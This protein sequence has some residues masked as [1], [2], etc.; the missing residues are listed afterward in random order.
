MNTG[1]HLQSLVDQ[2]S[3]QFN[4]MVVFAHEMAAEW[5][6]L[7][8]KDRGISPGEPKQEMAAE[9]IDLYCIELSH[10][11]T[12]CLVKE[13]VAMESEKSE[14]KRWIENLNSVK[15]SMWISKFIC[16]RCLKQSV[17]GQNRTRNSQLTS[18][19]Y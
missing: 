14:S 5:I 15:G 12:K 3:L 4:A 13:T 18:G 8:G 7:E 2:I 11:F 19:M 1:R 6:G 9:V 10:Y 17:V 16:G